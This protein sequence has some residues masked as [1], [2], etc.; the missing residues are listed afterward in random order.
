MVETGVLSCVAYIL[1]SWHLHFEEGTCKFKRKRGNDVMQLC[2]R[3]N[4]E[5]VFQRQFATCCSRFLWIQNS[6]TNALF[7]Y[8]IVLIFFLSFF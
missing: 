7:I 3:N 1:N 2:F 6:N 8:S 5:C 4:C